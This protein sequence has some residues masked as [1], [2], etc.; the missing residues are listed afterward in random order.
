MLMGIFSKEKFG[1]DLK[2]SDYQHIWSKFVFLDES[3][4]L[5][6]RTQPLFTVGFIKC[7]EPYYL[8]NKISYQRNKINFHDEMKFNKLSAHN[9]EFAKFVIDCFFSTR[10]L[11]FYSYT[12]DKGGNYFSA[13]YSG[14][15]WQAYEDI[16]VKVIKASIAPNEVLIIIA[17]HVTT[18]KNVRFEVSVKKRLNSELYRLAIAGVCRFDSKSN[19]LLQMT[20]LLIGAINYDLKRDLGLIGVGDKYKIE[21]VEHLKFNIG[22]KSFMSGHKDFNFNIFVDKDLKSRLDFSADL[23]SK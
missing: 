21:L 3:G 22:I 8:A 11:N 4:T 17:D 2:L 18:P 14:N 23:N 5:D 16:S 10:S 6:N 13:T 19:D 20:D 9:I 12:L 15:H 7:S 1:G